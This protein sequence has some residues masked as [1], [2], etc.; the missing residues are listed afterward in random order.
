MRN[1]DRISD[2]ELSRIVSAPLRQR[3]REK[4]T[5]LEDDMLGENVLDASDDVFRLAL[6]QFDRFA[7]AAQYRTVRSEIGYFAELLSVAGLSFALL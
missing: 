1:V 7:A 4:G 3:A 6:G 5:N 2:V